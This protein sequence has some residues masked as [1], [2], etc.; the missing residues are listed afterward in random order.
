MHLGSP[1]GRGCYTSPFCRKSYKILG[2]HLY[3]CPERHNRD[4]KKY[5]KTSKVANDCPG[6]KQVFNRLDLHLKSNKSCH[7]FS[8]DKFNSIL[9]PQQYQ[10]SGSMDNTQLLTPTS[11]SGPSESFPLKPHLI[12]PQKDDLG[13]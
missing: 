11:V 3:L 2:Q 9:Q 8:V 5:L 7:L 13:S 6:C 1:Y 12:L 4:Y 10:H